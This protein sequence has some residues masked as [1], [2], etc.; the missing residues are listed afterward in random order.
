MPR[1]FK[2]QEAYR[3]H[4]A[5]QHIHNVPHEPGEEVVIA[6]KRHKPKPAEHCS[7]IGYCRYHREVHY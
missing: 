7:K 5:Y 4:K 1:R 2:S 3:K 6:G